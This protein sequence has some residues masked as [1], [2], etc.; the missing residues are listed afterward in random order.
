[1][2][3]WA[4]EKSG[5]GAVLRLVSYEL[6]FRHL[7]ASAIREKNIYGILCSPRSIETYGQIDRWTV[8]GSWPGAILCFVSDETHVT[9]LLASARRDQALNVNQLSFRSL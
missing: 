2:D 1:M 3:K 8:E 4:G 6:T 9:P 5:P 7:S